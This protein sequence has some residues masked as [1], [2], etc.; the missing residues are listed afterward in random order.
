MAVSK[1]LRYEVLRR[2]N[3]ACRYCGGAAPDVKLVIDHVVP[4]WLGGTDDPTNL[5]TACEPCNTGKS[6]ASPD[7]PVV[8]DVSRDAWRWAVARKAAADLMLVEL[9]AVQAYRKAFTDV[10][11][12]WKTPAGEGVPRP[13]DWQTTIDRFC[14]AGLPREVMVDAVL[15]AMNNTTL[16]LARVFR[17]FCGIAWRRLEQMDKL[18]RELVDAALAIN[19]G[20]A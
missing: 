7:A 19:A 2:D 1:R 3:H 17:Y 5:V 12:D 10:W 6:S 14:D 15:I 13:D 16:P 9:E 20:E 18:T 11:G 4:V 8:A